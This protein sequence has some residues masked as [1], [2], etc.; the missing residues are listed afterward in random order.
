MA[1]DP[2]NFAEVPKFFLGGIDK[3]RETFEKMC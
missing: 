3:F 2:T 1:T